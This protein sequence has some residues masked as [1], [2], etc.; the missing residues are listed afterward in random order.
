MTKHTPTP[1][2]RGDQSFL[3]TPVSALMTADRGVQDGPS[4][5]LGAVAVDA[6]RAWQAD[7]RPVRVVVDDE[8]VGVVPERVLQDLLDQSWANLGQ[9]VGPRA[10][11]EVLESFR[12]DD[13]SSVHPVGAPSGPTRLVF[14]GVETPVGEVIDAFTGGHGYAHV[15]IDCGWQDRAGVRLILEANGDGVVFS[16]L[17]RYRESPI[18]FVDVEDRLVAH[19]SDAA[20]YASA[21]KRF[22]DQP[23]DTLEAVTGTDSDPEAQICS[24]LV[25]MGLPSALQR[26]IFRDAGHELAGDPPPHPRPRVSPNDLARYL[27]L[28]RADLI[29]DEGAVELEE[30]AHAPLPWR[31][32][33]RRGD[34]GDAVADLHDRLRAHGF[35]FDDE[36][37]FGPMTRL[38][39]LDLQAEHGMD[40]DGIVDRMTWDLLDE[41]P[42]IEETLPPRRGAEVKLAVPYLS[43]RDNSNRPEATCNV[44]CLAMVLSYHGCRPHTDQQFEDE[45]YDLIQGEEGLAHY[46]E[47][48][49]VDIFGANWRN[50]CTIH[51]M[52]EWAATRYGRRAEFRM[53]GR[54]DDIWTH[55][56]QT[57]PVI[58]AGRFTGSGHL[59]NLVGRTA[60]G[61]LIVHDPWGDWMQMYRGAGVCAEAGRYAIYPWNKAQSVLNNAGDRVWS[62][63]IW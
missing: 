63:F 16:P 29:M 7:R 55:V 20:A 5:P 57:G 51:K 6:L 60:K 38:A 42:P 37:T 32:T 1:R 9:A 15:A 33:L 2:A 11:G 14:F 3:A 26:E 10:R 18:A 30:A 13:G 35:Q 48:G 41:E 52:L 59:V 25:V 28:A 49:L 40:A 17:H 44:T 43:Q 21:L 58:L 46:N 45:L 4:V 24:G 12:G 36:A 8:T 19:G 54:W 31:P 34:G 53:Q 22:L 23:Y 47:S 27:G 61:D 50:R 62:H 39:V 56:E